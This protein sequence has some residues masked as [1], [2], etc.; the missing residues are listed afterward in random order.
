[1]NVWK[2]RAMLQSTGGLQPE[3]GMNEQLQQ[4]K[5]SM[6]GERNDMRESSNGRVLGS[7]N[8][9]SFADV[10]RGGAGTSSQLPRGG[11]HP[12]GGT[13]GRAYAEENQ[14]NAQWYGG[15][16]NNGAMEGVACDSQQYNAF[17]NPSD[18]SSGY[19][20]SMSSGQ[21]SM[22]S[23][24]ADIPFASMAQASMQH[25]GGSSNG[26]GMGRNSAALNNADNQPFLHNPFGLQHNGF[27]MG[28]RP[29]AH[30]IATLGAAAGKGMERHYA[31]NQ[32]VGKEMGY[33][34]QYAEVMN[35]RPSHLHTMEAHNMTTMS[36]NL[37]GFPMG[38]G[39]DEY[40]R[41][42]P[43]HGESFGRY[44]AQPL[45]N[46]HPGMWHQRTQPKY[47]NHMKDMNNDNSM[48][49]GRSGKSF[50]S[51][52]GFG[53]NTTS[54]DEHKR[55]SEESASGSDQGAYRMH[56]GSVAPSVQ[57]ND[58]VD[59]RDSYYQTQG[60]RQHRKSRGSN[61]NRGNKGYRKLWQ[62]VTNVSKGGRLSNQRQSSGD[63]TVEDLLEIVL[64]LPSE[65]PSVPAVMNGLHSLDAGALAALLKE[66]NRNRCTQ[67]AQEIFDWL[68][69]LESVH[70]LSHLCTTMTY[71]TMISQCGAQ[72]A[73]RRAMELMA[74]MRS[75]EIS[76]NV[77]TYSALMNVCIKAGELELALDVYK[78][79]L[80]E[81]CT[82]NLV[83]FNTLIDV[84]G[85]TGQWEEAIAVL[86]AVEEQG[87]EPEAR[88]YNTAIIACNQSARAVEA[89]QVYERMLKARARPTATTYTALISAYGKA[90]Q[91]EEALRIFESMGK[92]GCEKN[93][94]TYS[95]L[96]SACE[97]AGEWELAMRLFNDMHQDGCQPNVVTYNSLIAACAQGAQ[98]Q[99][100]QQIFD[101]MRKRGCRPDSVTFGALIGAYDRS[102][103]WRSALSSF[104]AIRSSGCRPDT[105]VYN[106][107]VGC[108]WRTGILRAQERSLQIFH[109]A[110]KQGHFRMTIASEKDQNGSTLSGEDGSDHLLY[111]RE[112]MSKGQSPYVE[113][114]MHAFTIGSAILCLHRWLCELKLRNPSDGPVVSQETVSLVLN[115]GKPS[116]EHTY[117]VIKEA[118][119]AKLKAW[120]APLNLVDVPVGC[121]IFGSKAEIV[122]WLRRPA[123]K[124][125]LEQ[126]TS[127]V[128]QESTVADSLYQD[129]AITESRCNEAFR[130]VVQFESL[131]SSEHMAASELVDAGFQQELFLSM[132]TMAKT[133][134]YP[135]DILYD[136]FDI[137]TRVLQGKSPEMVSLP[138][139][140]L[141]PACFFI[142]AEQ[143]SY[144]LPPISNGLPDQNP[145]QDPRVHE[146][147]QEIRSKF[148]GN[149]STISP[150]RVLKLYL[151]RLGA[152]F[153]GH[154]PASHPVSG[155]SFALLPLA[156]SNLNLRSFRASISA[157]AVL[158]VGRKNAGISP[159]WPQALEQMTGYKNDQG[160]NLSD[161]VQLISTLPPGGTLGTLNC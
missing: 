25:H 114:G 34:V 119:V 144:G 112:E 1:M 18:S 78:Q 108:L 122:A 120:R 12:A 148:K 154:A 93:V 124:S 48:D 54:I 42:Y 68:R 137:L 41:L 150:I 5:N 84:Y 51:S 115:K 10:A 9:I 123:M 60:Q 133:F 26:S 62:Q 128:S 87:L 32:I 86:D 140:M 17:Q 74:E 101:L 8:G 49:D 110:C 39:T 138:R 132:G 95:S 43:Q 91:L 82:P 65:L 61:D 13:S 4:R 100:A 20:W 135:E 88:T 29:D 103:N 161:A 99:K 70:P 145:L 30:E 24:E 96:I 106:T 59:Q 28:Y 121:K 3:A 105:V 33:P 81:G 44:S 47:S 89:L 22:F 107:I 131:Q 149:M 45:Q 55:S 52:Q 142:A 31:P 53:S 125:A 2:Q 23:A 56:L 64:A 156:V 83:T 14:N 127:Y 72:H 7:G 141:V 159:F 152:Y 158:I 147:S 16:S 160:T 35:P 46:T 79:M 66:L 85:K 109:S 98:A 111:S 129:D 116:R 21:P 117:P 113:F 27:D 36:H 37:G 134:G 69:Q 58:G 6:H 130:A 146:L 75:R 153:E 50:S 57:S 77:H 139:E 157:A 94:I 38:P 73:L 151:E 92:N 80:N 102:G 136:G 97:K 19:H 71:T 90:G 40:Y 15:K 126:F 118:L 155:L 76:C 143:S 67:R 11:V 63:T 104:E